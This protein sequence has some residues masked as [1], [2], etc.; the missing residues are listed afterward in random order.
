MTY[1]WPFREWPDAAELHAI[2][3]A[4]CER[5]GHDIPHDRETNEPLPCRH[6]GISPAALEALEEEADA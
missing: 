5:H 4:D 2:A 6:C 1:P 3:Y